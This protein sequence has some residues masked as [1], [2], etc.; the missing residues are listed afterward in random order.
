[1]NAG[2]D[3]RRSAILRAVVEAYIDAAEPVGSAYLAALPGMRVS[4][5]TIRNEMSALEGEGYLQQPHTSAGRVPTEK[6]YRRYVDELMTSADP[7]PDRADQVQGFFAKAHQEIEELLSS[8]TRL[9]TRMTDLAAVVTGPSARRARIVSVQLVALSSHTV[10]VV[11][12]DANGSVEK[13]T[14]AWPGEA[15]PGQLAEISTVLT[16]HFRDR[17]VRDVDSSPRFEDAELDKL[18]AYAFVA[19]REA[20][21][22]ADRDGV[23][24]EGTSRIA[25]SFGA[26]ETV[27]DVISILERHYLVVTLMRSLLSR[28]QGVSIGS[29]HGVSSLRECAVVVAPYSVD[30]VE[31]G[32][33]G[34]IGPTRMNYA[35]A[36]G[37]A[38]LVSENLTR[39]LS[40]G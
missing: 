38:N 17:E 14:I 5:A 11:V 15:D 3:D 9:L 24:I 19:V 2:V 20:V 13:R 40:E 7:G 25:A 35:S 31:V 8:T 21:R 34:L 29:E 16:S 10:V 18:G 26:V 39:R 32:T 36:I 12:V 23:F 33:I 4:P 30:G 27:R 6:G 37:V 22:D 1:M 28:G